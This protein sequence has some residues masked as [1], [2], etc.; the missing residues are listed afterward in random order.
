MKLK[1]MVMIAGLLALAGLWMA[2]LLP[3]AESP[4]YRE[5]G[6]CMFVTEGRR[7][8]DNSSVFGHDTSCASLKVQRAA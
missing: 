6:N 1:V 3:R 4:I 5:Q 2:A 8:Q 7:D